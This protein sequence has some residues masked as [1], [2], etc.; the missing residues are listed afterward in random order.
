MNKLAILFF[1]V[2]VSG[3]TQEVI[4]QDDLQADV[5]DFDINAVIIECDSL[6]NVNADAYCLESRVIEVNGIEINGTCRAFSK[7]GHVEGF[8]R[9]N[10]YC[11]DYDISTT[12]CKVNEAIDENCDGKI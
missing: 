1:V 12:M 10:G 8:N 11:S 2:F 6:C 7:T 3:C 9:C 4:I 5:N